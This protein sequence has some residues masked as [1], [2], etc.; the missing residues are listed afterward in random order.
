MLKYLLLWYIQIS[1]P[2][3]TVFYEAVG[4]AAADSDYTAEMGPILRGASSV[5]HFA[6]RAS[7]VNAVSVLLVE[8]IADRVGLGVSDPGPFQQPKVGDL[9]RRIVVELA[10]K[11]WNPVSRSQLFAEA[12]LYVIRILD[13][14][15]AEEGDT[16]VSFKAGHVR[17]EPRVFR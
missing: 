1:F 5:I 17:D 15:S 14:V 16:E 9:E 4:K 13:T 2:Q 7:F 11:N 10:K 6:K 3:A 8:F 12:N